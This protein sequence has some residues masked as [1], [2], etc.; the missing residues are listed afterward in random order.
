[1]PV[2]FIKPVNH[3]GV[4]IIEMIMVIVVVGILTGIS[5]MYIKETVDLYGFI[6]F[7][8]EVAAQGRMAVL[9]LAREMR[10]MKVR[11]QSYEPIIRAQANLCEFVFK[12]GAND[13]DVTYSL[14]GGNLVRTVAAADI[15]A[16]NVTNLQFCYYDQT[17]NS[18]C[19]PACGC[20]VA[21]ANLDTIYRIVI[22]LDIASGNQAKH[23]ELQVYPRN[24]H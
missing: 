11:T 17:N 9:R 6:T 13:V 2:K 20:S 14:S 15:L 1:M 3:K 19:A 22:K 24:L 10:E 8:N 12:D 16:S 21:A 5:S 18:V 4:T 7:R 23:L